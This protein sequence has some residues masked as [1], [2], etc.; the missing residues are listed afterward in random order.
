MACERCGGLK[1]HDYFYGATDLFAWQCFGFRCV[2]CGAISNI[3]PIQPSDSS[4]S[5]PR[6]NMNHSRIR[7]T[8][9]HSRTR[10]TTVVR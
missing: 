7:Q 9:H 5:T 3:Q 1:V 10:Q 2:N 8:T 6:R 4:E